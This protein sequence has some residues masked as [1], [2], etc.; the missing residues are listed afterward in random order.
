MGTTVFLDV[1]ESY[2]QATLF[3]NSP[4]NQELVL[5][6]GASL[7]VRYDSLSSLM[8]SSTSFFHC[9]CSG[10]G[11]SRG[12]RFKRGGA[13]GADEMDDDGLHFGSH[14]VSPAII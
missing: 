1:R 14:D 7:L 3:T 9:R 5:A 13:Y 10:C 12:G 4:W 6:A 11:R 2:V 8:P